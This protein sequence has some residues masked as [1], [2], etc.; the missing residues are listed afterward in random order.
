MISICLTGCKK[1]KKDSHTVVSGLILDKVT[2]NRVPNA[3]VFLGIVESGVGGVSA[4]TEAQT[5]SDAAGRYSFD[6]TASKGKD[7]AIIAKADKYF[8]TE[9][10]SEYQ[11][12]EGEKNESFHIFLKP[13]ATIKIHVKKTDMTYDSLVF[14]SSFGA[15]TGTLKAAFGKNVDTNLFY[16]NQIGGLN[17][18]IYIYIEKFTGQTL[19]SGT[20]YTN[21]VYF[22]PVDTTYINLNY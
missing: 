20:S 17:K 16:L 14:S 8:E 10:V 12:R 15:G 22:I 19:I 4:S 2:G 7:Y 13:K 1:C 3:T 5:T 18:Y 6:F 11:I 9:S 21:A